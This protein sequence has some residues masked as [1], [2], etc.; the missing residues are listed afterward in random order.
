[1]PP[2]PLETV[3]SLATLL[4][5]AHRT[6]GKKRAALQ[7]DVRSGGNHSAYISRYK[8]FSGLANLASVNPKDSGNCKFFHSPGTRCRVTIA[9]FAPVS[10]AL[11]GK[12]AQ[13]HSIRYIKTGKT[14]STSIS[15][16]NLNTLHRQKKNV[17]P[18]EG[19]DRE[20]DPYPYIGSPCLVGCMW[21]VACDGRRWPASLLQASSE[22][23]GKIGTL[24]FNGLVVSAT[25]E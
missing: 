8:S 10:T 22:L 6:P 15:T 25:L 19:K 13:K 16:Q 20:K 24:E 21:I 1:M 17:S 23:F 9:A 4:S 12:N 5:A 7:W 14:D 11:N 3:Q 18:G 2:P